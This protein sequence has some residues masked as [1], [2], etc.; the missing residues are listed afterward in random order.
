M[1]GSC[2]LNFQ[3]KTNM[4]NVTLSLSCFLVCSFYA[5]AQ[6]ITSAWAPSPWRA[7]E[8]HYTENVSGVSPGAAGSGQTW[9]FSGL[10]DDSVNIEEIVPP[11]GLPEAGLF[12]TA[13]HASV[14]T[15]GDGVTLATYFQ[16]SASA[17]TLL[18]AGIAGGGNTGSFNYT[19]PIDL[20]RFPIGFGQAYNDPFESTIT[21]IGF[22]FQRNGAVQVDVDGSGTLST[23]IGTFNN[24]LRVK[25]VETYN[26]LGLPPIPGSST[27]GVVTTYN[28][29]SA[30]YPGAIL[31]SYVIDDDNIGNVDTTIGF[32]DPNFQSIADLLTEELSVFPVPASDILHIQAGTSVS[33]VD[34]FDINGRSIAQQAVNSGNLLKIDVAD[35]PAGV[36]VIRIFLS[37]G[38]I[39][40]RRV[41]ITH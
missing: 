19:N 4:K 20:F 21:A 29:I 24:V 6:T 13:T 10:S 12:G 16:T 22:S 34:L 30:D 11:A 37:N 32:A 1:Q 7:N 17:Y 38:S 8:I 25:S 36:Y 40:N 14:V 28:F 2:L 5:G 23:P 39:S 33:S 3:K 9:D 26:L 31:L 35:I 41:I 15:D 18:G 27:S